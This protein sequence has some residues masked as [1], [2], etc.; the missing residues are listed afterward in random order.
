M[1]D[2]GVGAGVVLGLGVG[3]LHGVLPAIFTTDEAVMTT[4]SFLLVLAAL[5]QPLNGLVFTLDGILIGAGDL[6]YLARA[7]VISGI[8]F[9]VGAVAVLA[10]DAGIGWLWAALGAWMAA[11]AITLGLRYRGSAWQVVGAG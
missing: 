10:T 5:L 7:M 9:G 3:A 11:R 4:A 1:I 2:W 8:V 6:R